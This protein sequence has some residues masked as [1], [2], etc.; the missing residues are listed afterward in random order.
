MPQFSAPEALLV[1]KEK[2]LDIPFIIV[3]G[4]IGEERAVAALLSGAS[5]FIS[6]DNMA[7]LIPAIE[8]GLRDAETRRAKRESEAALLDLEARYRHLFESNPVPL[9]VY[10]LETL[11]FLAVNSAA[12]GHYGYSREEFLS[13]TLKDIRPA[14]DVPSLLEDVAAGL[15]ETRT[16]QHR[17]KDGTLIDVEITAHDI[18][19]GRRKA[20]LVLSN[21]RD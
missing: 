12:I 2:Q 20:R 16:W 3:S 11:A 18:E 19:F 7:R 5:D 8:R 14:G 21:Q 1:V 15:N 17:K 6:K 10:D 9:W 4:T 13:M